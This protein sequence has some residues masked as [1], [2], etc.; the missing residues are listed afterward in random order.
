MDTGLGAGPMHN[1]AAVRYRP[2]L[3]ALRELIAAETRPTPAAQTPPG[4]VDQAIL[5][6]L[7]GRVRQVDADIAAERAGFQ[8]ALTEVTECGAA[9]LTQASDVVQSAVSELRQACGGLD[10]ATR[11]LVER[12]ML[13][14]AANL[15]AVAVEQ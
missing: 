4:P 7:R 13:H 2:S 5:D 1:Y 15:R 11:R 10:V 8:T 12:I 9:E 3:T 6:A 14:E